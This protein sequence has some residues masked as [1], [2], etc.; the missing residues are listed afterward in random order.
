M[1]SGF[2]VLVWFFV[3]LMARSSA[4]TV[5]EGHAKGGFQREENQSWTG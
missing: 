2:V 1:V 5:G 3:K 4:E